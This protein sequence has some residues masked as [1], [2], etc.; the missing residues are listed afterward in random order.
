M[1]IQPVTVRSK[2]MAVPSSR[3]KVSCCCNV[4]PCQGSDVEHNQAAY[5]QTCAARSDVLLKLQIITLKFLSIFNDR[6][7][8]KCVQ[9]RMNGRSYWH[10]IYSLEAPTVGICSS[11]HEEPIACEWKA[12]TA[13]WL[14]WI[15]NC[16]GTQ[17][18]PRQGGNIK[19]DQVIEYCKEETALLNTANQD[20]VTFL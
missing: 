19:L 6:A 20:N 3:H 1:H 8:N 11:M 10:Q 15:A 13:R 18:R 17:I 14:W 12:H 4:C 9:R 2:S 7:N 5:I 16:R